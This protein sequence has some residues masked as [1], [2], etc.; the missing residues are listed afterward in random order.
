MRLNTG[1]STRLMGTFSVLVLAPVGLTKVKPKFDWGWPQKLYRSGLCLL[2]CS[3]RTETVSE[4][5][6]SPKLKDEAKGEHQPLKDVFVYSCGFVDGRPATLPGSPPTVWPDPKGE[7]RGQA[8]LPLYRSAPKAALKD[9][10]LYELLV[11]VD[12]IR[13]GRVREKDLAVKE[14]QK[15]LKS[16]GKKTKSEHWDPDC[17]RKSIRAI[18]QW[19]GFSWGFKKQF[20]PPFAFS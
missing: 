10:K 19:N 14:M 15:R 6:H 8:F 20:C 5:E 2:W 11:L 13:G 9:K 17:S 7:I 4:K 18:S 12:A 1:C 3:R 16:Y